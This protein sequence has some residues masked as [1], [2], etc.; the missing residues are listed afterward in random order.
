LTFILEL[1]A[2]LA[3]LGYA[4][5]VVLRNRWAW[6]SG[7]MSSALLS[8]LAFGAALP[9]QAALQAVYVLMAIY[10]FWHWSQAGQGAQISI[11]RWATWMHLLVGII[12]LSVVGI[13]AEFFEKSLGSA[14]PRLDAAVTCLSLCATVMTARGVLENWVYWWAVNAASMWLYSAQGLWGVTGL[15]AVYFLIALVGWQRWC[16]V[17]RQQVSGCDGSRT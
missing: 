13:G 3:G 1:L 7:A 2:L 17:Y 6:A 9:L 14:W 12:T 15:Y 8:L 10:G 5:G 16:R 4:I 11:Q